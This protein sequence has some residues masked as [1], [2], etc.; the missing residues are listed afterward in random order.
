[1]NSTIANCRPARTED[2]SQ[3][4]DVHSAA[5]PGFFLTTLGPGFLRTMYRAFIS[6]VG[7]VFVINEQN[8]RLD[9]FAVGILKS[10]GKD[11]NLAVRFLPQFIAALVPGLIRNPVKVM[12]RVATQFFSVGEEPEVPNNSVIL[13]SIG[14]LPDAKGSGVASRLLDEFERLSRAKGAT[15]VA[16]TTDALDNERAVG[17]YRK[18]GYHIAQEFSQDKNRKMLLMLKDLQ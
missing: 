7:G 5:F 13:R 14:V 1:M 8:N 17:F 6:N 10:A 18:H 9:G 3:V 16:L 15:S 4:A 2:V 12:R 11:R